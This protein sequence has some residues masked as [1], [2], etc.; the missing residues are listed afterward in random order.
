M[1]DSPKFPHWSGLC[2]CVHE[3]IAYVIAGSDDGKIRIWNGNTGKLA[4]VKMHDCQRDITLPIYV[5][6]FNKGARCH[7]ISANESVIKVWLFHEASLRLIMS[8]PASINTNYAGMSVFQEGGMHYL[9]Y[10]EEGRVL[11]RNVFTG[12]QLMMLEPKRILCKAEC[13][14]R[15]LNVAEAASCVCTYEKDA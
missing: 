3:N 10:I 13:N 11:I 7:V 8:I 5:C 14:Q 15:H 2:T 9:L 1:S 12:K 4:I 6:S